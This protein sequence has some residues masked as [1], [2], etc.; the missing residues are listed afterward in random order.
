MRAT[1]GST[2]SSGTF[3]SAFASAHIKVDR[4]AEYAKHGFCR[5]L[6]TLVRTIDQVYEL[7]PPEQEEIPD[8][9]NVVDATIAI[10]AFTMSAAWCL[11]AVRNL[12]FEPPV[13]ILL[14]LDIQRSNS[15]FFTENQWFIADRLDVRCPMDRPDRS[16]GHGVTDDLRVPGI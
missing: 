6:E 12:S 4:G 3:R 10:Q 16:L 7:L 13:H 1:R 15:A 8:R 9:E 14:T 2:G 5:R 11:P